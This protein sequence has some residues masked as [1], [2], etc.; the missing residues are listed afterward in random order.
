[1]DGSLSILSD[2]RA[3]QKT[4]FLKS[5][6]ITVIPKTLKRLL[7]I[8]SRWARGAGRDKVEGS[9]ICIDRF[10]RMVCNGSIRRSI[11]SQMQPVV[12]N[13]G[14]IPRYNMSLFFFFFR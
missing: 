9:M 13:K 1:L 5:E 6:A 14:Y 2:R 4:L 7:N 3:K 8:I 10:K 12:L 11:A